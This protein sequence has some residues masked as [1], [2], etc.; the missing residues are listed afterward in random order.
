MEITPD[1]LEKCA[2]EKCT[3]EEEMTIGQWLQ[4]SNPDGKD[5][6]ST[7]TPFQKDKRWEVIY[8]DTVAEKGLKRS[9]KSVLSV[10]ASVALLISVG[11]VFKLFRLEQEVYTTGVREANV[12]TFADNTSITLNSGSQL[13]VTEDFG[14][15]IRN[16]TFSREAYFKVA[17][18]V[19]RPFIILAA[20]SRTEVLGIE[21]NLK[22]YSE[23]DVTLT[24]MEGKAAFSGL[25]GGRINQ[26]GQL[27]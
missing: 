3:L 12:I 26:L 27:F 5:G 7:P 2:Q 25:A 13:I 21:F 22:S 19:Y 16:V 23:E 10:A 8:A 1:L 24:L 14:D 15:D 9:S 11:L 4:T 17:K 18:D 6:E 20:T